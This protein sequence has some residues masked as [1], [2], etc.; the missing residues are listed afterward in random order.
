M[1][2]LKGGKCDYILG[3]RQ[4]SKGKYGGIWQG[5]AVDD[6]RSVTV[7][8]ITSYGEAF[9]EMIRRL[10]TVEH[11]NVA[12]TTDAFFGEDRCFY[13]VREYVDGTDLKSIF[14]NKRLYRKIDEMRFVEAGK[15]VL[16]ALKAV[17]AAGIVHRDV[18]PANIVVRHAPETNVLD[19]DFSDVVLVDFEQGSPFPDTRDI[20]SSFAL[21]YS[22]PEMLLKYNHLV[23][24]P[25]DLFAL[26]VSLFQL[27]M[28]KAPYS[29]CNPEIL[30]NLQLTYPMQQP[31]RMD[32]A[33]YAVLSKAAYKVPFRVPPRRMSVGEIE[34]ILQ[35]GVA[36][37]YQSAEEMLADLEKVQT[38]FKKVNWFVRKFVD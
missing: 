9:Q 23:G 19:A 22:P 6:G 5:Q 13:V 24:P 7:K 2:V 16:R 21:I 1:E 25:S 38:P 29:D 31:V 35:K 3:E 26:S 18:K 15:S 4:G 34:E 30:V 20:R 37:R 14:M 36:G 12:T 11:P 10:L 27:I 8:R 32:D 28:G 33:L 17:H